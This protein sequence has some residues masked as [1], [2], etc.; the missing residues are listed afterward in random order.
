VK[1]EE[2]RGCGGRVKSEGHII[3]TRAKGQI[4]STFRARKQCPLMRLVKVG[5]RKGKVLGSE[6]GKTLKRNFVT[7]RGSM[8]LMPYLPHRKRTIS[9]LQKPLN[10]FRLMELLHLVPRIVCNA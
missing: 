7:S 8:K 10:E 9:P 3:L 5:G 1:P 6:E 4:Y 2:R